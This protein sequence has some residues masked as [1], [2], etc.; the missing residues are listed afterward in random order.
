MSTMSFAATPGGKS[1]AAFHEER[2]A[3]YSALAQ[4]LGGAT[5][6][7]ERAQLRRRLGKI[8]GGQLRVRELVERVLLESAADETLEAWRSSLAST[9]V[10]DLHVLHEVAQQAGQCAR[11]LYE[12]DMASAADLWD[13]QRRDFA[14]SVGFALRGVAV[15]LIHTRSPQLAALG[16]ALSLLLDD[17]LALA[18]LGA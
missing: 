14:G 16:Q 6:A 5:D 15:E 18:G 2:A 11:A 13:A 1:L 12:G 7:L 3:L 9:R 4:L 10:D 17:D 8:R